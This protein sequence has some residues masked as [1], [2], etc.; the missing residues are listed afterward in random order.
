MKMM[1]INR[2]QCELVKLNLKQIKRRLGPEGGGK[3]RLVSVM[4]AM[5]LSV[6]S[7]FAG[8]SR[9]RALGDGMR[10]G[11]TPGFLLHGGRARTGL[12]SL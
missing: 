11:F 9:K 2:K 10:G 1:A 4:A 12:I 8:V 5:R 7:F 6:H 3:R